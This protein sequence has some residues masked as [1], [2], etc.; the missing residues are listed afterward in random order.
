MRLLRILRSFRVLQRAMSPLKRQ[1]MS[2]ALVLVSMLFINAGLINL[3]EDTLWVE[4]TG[5]DQSLAPGLTFG[6]SLWLSLVT[7]ATIGY[8]D[9]SPVTPL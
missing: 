6:N 9:Y 2:V 7:L 1:I 5:L 4:L 8:G 3:V